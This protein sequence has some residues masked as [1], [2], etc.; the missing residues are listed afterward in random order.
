M[1]VLVQQSCPSYVTAAGM[2]EKLASLQGM[3]G[4][5]GLGMQPGFVQG[6]AGHMH[7]SQPNQFLVPGAGGQGVAGHVKGRGG[8]AERGKGRGRGDRGPQSQTPRGS[9]DGVSSGE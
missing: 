5:E 6:R 1:P 4:N 7:T 9:M 3:G 8:L 2:Q